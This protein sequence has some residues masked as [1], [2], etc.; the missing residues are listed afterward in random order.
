MLNFSE[1]SSIGLFK[2]VTFR[3]LAALPCGILLFAGCLCVQ[4]SSFSIDREAT[5]QYDLGGVR[6]TEWSGGAL[7]TFVS[8]QTPA[9]V[10][11]SFDDRGR[12]LSPLILTIPESETIDLLD[13]ARGSDGMVVACGKVY[14]HSG[15]GTG[16]LAVFGTTGVELTVIRLYP[17]SP[18]RIAVTADGSIWTAGPEDANPMAAMDSTPP[19]SGVVRH[20]DR[21]G[22][23]I[24]AVIARSEFSSRFM[25]EYGWLRAAR[26]RIGWYTGPT[27]GPGSRYYEI[28]SDGTVRKYPVISINKSE[29]VNGLALTDDG[30]TYVTTADNRNHTWRFLSIGGPDQTWIQ[31]SLP[32]QFGRAFLYGAEGD[33]LVFYHRDRFTV[34]FVNVSN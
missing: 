29:V 17:Y 30:R 10:I 20:F 32:G 4:A 15:R 2:R 21:A 3:T 34:A 12:Q 23:M 11:L 22:K 33:R 27:N 6:M 7:V 5:I 13:A 8:N 28:L 25:V 9:P 26:G 31:P 18:S 19:G 14:D 16:F 24:G 1:N